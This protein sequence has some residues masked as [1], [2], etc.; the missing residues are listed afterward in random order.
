MQVGLTVGTAGADDDGTFVVTRD[1]PRD[2]RS[3]LAFFNLL[4]HDFAVGAPLKS[5]AGCAS[6]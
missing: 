3:N 2:P 1:D 6:S 5:G 4:N